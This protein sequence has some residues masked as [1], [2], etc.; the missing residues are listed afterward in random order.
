[1]PG[2][3]GIPISEMTNR[4]L[5]P[6]VPLVLTIA[7]ANL[8]LF[9]YAFVVEWSGGQRPVALLSTAL[10]IVF[11]AGLLAYLEIGFVIELLKRRRSKSGRVGEG[12]QLWDRRRTIR[13]T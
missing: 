3:R 5:L 12:Q 11:F 6:A 13:C 1:M 10:S 7:V 8:C 9:G 4:Q 2:G